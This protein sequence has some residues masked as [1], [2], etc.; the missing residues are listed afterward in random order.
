MQLKTKTGI[1]IDIQGYMEYLKEI[2][3]KAKKLAK[4]VIL[5]EGNEERTIR[6][7]KIILD[8]GIAKQVYLLGDEDEI[9]TRASN[10][11]V[12]LSGVSILNPKKSAKIE[13]YAE[14]YY[15]MRKAKGLSKEQALSEMKDE[16]TYGAMMLRKG[17]GDSLVSGAQNTT[18]NVLRAGFKLVGL[19]KGVTHASS[20]FIM[21]TPKKEFGTDGKLIFADCSVTPNP[22]EEELAE[23]AIASAKSCKHFLK[24]EPIV[25][26]LSFSTKGSA[27]TPE[28]EKVAKALS[29]IKQRAPELKVDG[30]MQLDA[31][32]IDSVGRAKAP[33]SSVAGKANV[34]VFPTLDAGNIGYK[35]V[36]RFGDTDAIGPVLQGFA[37]PISDLSRGC[38][39]DDIV[40]TVA[41][42]INKYEV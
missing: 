9:K 22:N 26:L 15:E 12:S 16:L 36:Q 11:A 35:L 10:L 23:I 20:F 1:L 41:L 7:S 13:E 31:A 38:S 2:K 18:A 39:V 34:L 28:T 40:N 8:E 42:T 27:K 29:I 30:E 32:I 6:A 21:I 37:K 14:E 24:T 19:E 17:E 33:G 3:E 25:A 5:P 4:S